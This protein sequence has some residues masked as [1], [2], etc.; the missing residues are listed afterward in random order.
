[1]HTGA[2][3]LT[4]VLPTCH[5]ALCLVVLSQRH[6]WDAPT[7]SAMTSRTVLLA[8]S[9]HDSRSIYALMLEHHGFRVV[10][11]ASGAD[12]HRI[13]C[14][15][16]PDVVV[17]ELLLAPVEGQPIALLLKRDQRTAG[18][19]V[20]GL[21]VLPANLGLTQG[22]LACDAYLVKPCTPTRLLR[23]VERLLQPDPARTSRRSAIGYPL[24]VLD[25]RR[26][27]CA[28]RPVPDGRADG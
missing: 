21:T 24:S 17:T 28:A 15:S 12:A 14:E 4:V 8:D 5:S 26:D 10:H 1:M 18:L 16:R 6:T 23:E 2:P 3:T 9:D 27:P 11:A 20:V 13:A 25:G 19:P 22:L 7:E